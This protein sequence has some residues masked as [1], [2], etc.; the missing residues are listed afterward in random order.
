MES[1]IS[2]FALQGIN[3]WNLVQ[4]GGILLLGALLISGIFRFIFGR[5]T[6]IGHAVSSSIAIIFI[7]LT[8]AMIIMFL[9]KF[10][11]LITPLP[12]AAFSSNTVSF[13]SIPGLSYTGA[14]EQLLSMI[15]LAFLVNLVE[16]WLPKKANILA[17]LFWKC[18]TVAF[19]LLLHYL[20]C[21]LFHRY[22]PTGIV[23][24]APVV[25]LAILLLMLLTGALRFVV[26][27]ILASV[28]PIIAG[29]YTFF[30]ATIVGKQITKAV[31][32]TGIV[33]G[34][35][36]LLHHF[37]VATLALTAAALIAYIPFL[38]MLIIVWYV[39]NRFL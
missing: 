38:L 6:L 17:W 39:V 35:V 4:A 2:Y 24:Y 20:I 32:T 31:L 33:A 25:L 36:Q 15:I 3:F 12:F 10:H 28:N 7:Y 13:L 1:I 16:I 37:G 29:L 27:F 14:S 34:V 30:F 19:G 21:W 18:V 5:K 22:L 23:I 11:W 8:M 9:P 26:G